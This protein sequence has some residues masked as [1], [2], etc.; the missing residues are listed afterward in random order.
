MFDGGEIVID[1][2]EVG[3][4]T[5]IFDSYRSGKTM[6]QIVSM[7][8]EEKIEFSED[9]PTWNVPKVMRIIGD[10]RY[11]GNDKFPRIISDEAYAEAQRIRSD[12]NHVA[13]LDRSYFL[14]RMKMP[15]ICPVCGS[16]MQRIYDARYKCKHA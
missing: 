10:E 7:L 5:V 2:D 14:Y 3:V 4:V 8:T 12:N 11:L 9:N 6:R 16:R 13:D 1:P 15:V